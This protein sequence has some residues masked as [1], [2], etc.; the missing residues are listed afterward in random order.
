MLD[1]ITRQIMTHCWP[2]RI[3]YVQFLQDIS[4]YVRYTSPGIVNWWSWQFMW[5]RAK[6]KQAA[7][8][9]VKRDTVKGHLGRKDT[10][11]NLFL[12]VWSDTV[13]PVTVLRSCCSSL[14]IVER[15]R[16]TDGHISVI[17]WGFMRPRICF[18]P[19]Y[20]L[21]SLILAIPQ[22]VNNWRIHS[23]WTKSPFFRNQF[24]GPCN[25]NS[26]RR[27]MGCTALHTT[28][29]N[30]RSSLYTSQRLTYSPISL[31][32]EGSPDILIHG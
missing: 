23:Y 21:F 12:A 3:L 6:R 22:P 7:R 28:R 9:G 17:L 14:A 19:P 29:S 1:G 11:R 2:F 13:S 27:L 31:C 4:V 30:D 25:L 5:L 20:E 32:F 15:R 26:L 8:C 10:S 18:N 16:N 24:D